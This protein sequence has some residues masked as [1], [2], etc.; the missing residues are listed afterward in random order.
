MLSL[1]YYHV[2]YCRT[3]EVLLR[4]KSII[5][6]PLFRRSRSCT[7]YPCTA[8]RLFSPCLVFV[9]HSFVLFLMAVGR[10]NTPTGFVSYDNRDSAEKAIS[11]MNGYQV[12]STQCCQ[13][14]F[15]EKNVG[16]RHV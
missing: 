2:V 6:E 4:S 16:F 13:I 14:I 9:L 7:P 8:V 15:I 12:G 10:M 3:F 5:Y 1:R 11:Q